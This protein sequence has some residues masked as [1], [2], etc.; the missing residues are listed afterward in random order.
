MV[1]PITIDTVREAAKC[2]EPYAHR[3]PVMTCAALDERA[4]R[5]VFFKCEN[6]QK[7]GAFKFRG[8]CNAVMN[9]TDHVAG[10][11]V[12]TH[13]SGNHAQALASAAKLRGIEAHIVMPSTASPVK[14]AAV[15]GYGGTVYVCEP[16]DRARQQR[17]EELVAKT[18]GTLI[19]PFDHPHVIAGQGT[20]A[21]ELLD[22]VATLGAIV[23]PIGGGGLMSGTCTAAR[24]IDPSIRLF[25]AEPAGADDA[26]RS[27]AAGE[28][29]PQTNPNTI[30]DGL[31]TSMGELTWPI[32]R[33]HVETIFT[34]SDEQVI[35]AMRF[36]LQR[37]KIVIEPSAAVA[38]AAVLSD[39]FKSLG[40]L[41][42]VGV[43][44]SGGNVDL[45]HLPW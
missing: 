27:L 29:V 39:Q 40:G 26:A 18:G 33:D 12:V 15:E 13:S 1:T 17:A 44:I 21:L 5:R 38:V 42:R 7:I 14:R 11:G 9:L 45:D 36:I 23:A 30:C 32:I 35:E 43:I 24:G 37:M 25:G 34:V 2:I 8:A 6:F 20:A 22:E 10:R 3:T 28:L 19:P 4:G 41:A 16:N 31:L